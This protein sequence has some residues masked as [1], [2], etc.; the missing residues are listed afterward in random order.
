MKTL[1]MLSIILVTVAV[2]LIA[3]RDPHVGRGIRRMI[4]LLLAFN[5]LYLGYLT[6]VHAAVFVPARW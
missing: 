5:A 3:A 2:P 1:G 4:V 6:L